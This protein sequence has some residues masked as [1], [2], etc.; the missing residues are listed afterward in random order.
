MSQTISLSG[1]AGGETHA[2]TLG[3]TVSRNR[4]TALGV[5][6]A[7][8]TVEGMRTLLQI[9]RMSG[10]PACR[11]VAGT[12]HAITHPRALEL[13]L[14]S[15]WQVRLGRAADGRGIFHPKLLVAGSR[16]T[17]GGGI[18]NLLCMYVGSANM[19]A[20][21][22]LTNAECGILADGEDCPDAGS[23]AF[24]AIWRNARPATRTELRNYAAHFAE[25]ARK[26]S[27]S[28]LRAL[29][30]S[31]AAAVAADAAELARR[32]PPSDPA[33]DFGFAIAA[34]TGLQSFTGEYRFQI[35]FPRRAG[36][37]VSKLLLGR[38]RQTGHVEVYCPDDGVTR[39]MRYRY[40][41]DNSM[42]RLNVP[43]DVPGVV[44]ARQHRQ[45]IALVESGPKMGAALRLRLLKP[46]AEADNVAGRSA[47][48]GT[49]G[50]TP[51]RA[52]GWF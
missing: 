9:A 1:L 47:A 4:P 37:V 15:G 17:R 40:Y 28:E 22:F 48:L 11:L 33:I 45:G 12:D 10:R 5:V 35:E 34:W 23:S 36:D 43:N 20:G 49:W 2:A 7:F 6:S 50:R 38:T 52:Y 18:R 31:D 42:F 27:P 44:W 16:F 41:A 21:G 3:R 19:T 29:G 25:C 46:G 26:R 51:T 14:D 8:V 13:A 32:A 24:A 39:P 30:I